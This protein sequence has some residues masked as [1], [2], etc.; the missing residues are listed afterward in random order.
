MS[1]RAHGVSLEKG[2]TMHN[3]KLR[4]S[5]REALDYL[6]SM[7]RELRQIAEASR[8]PTI[9]YFLDMAYLETADVIRGVRPARPGR[10]ANRPGKPGGPS[11]EELAI[12][13]AKLE[14]AQ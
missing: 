10:P 8:F 14:A 11:P 4:A 13:Y 7:I 1:T 9:A 5:E 3:P 6:M 2:A 12:A